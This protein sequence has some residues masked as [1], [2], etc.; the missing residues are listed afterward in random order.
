MLLLFYAIGTN[1]DAPVSSLAGGL[2]LIWRSLDIKDPPRDIPQVYIIDW[3]F[4]G[5]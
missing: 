2:T 5:L 1:Y 4:L 3:D